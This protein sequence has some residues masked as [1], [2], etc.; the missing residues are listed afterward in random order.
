[1][2]I[3]I[4]CIEFH[5][6]ILFCEAFEILSTQRAFD[7]V[8]VVWRLAIWIVHHRLFAS[9]Y[10]HTV[11]AMTLVVPHSVPSV[12]PLT[13]FGPREMWLLMMCLLSY[14]W[15]AFFCLWT[16]TAVS[17]LLPRSNWLLEIIPIETRQAISTILRFYC[18]F[19]LRISWCCF[20]VRLWISEENKMPVFFLEK[21]SPR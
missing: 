18:S 14:H 9:Y 13:V 20:P 7:L 4:N 1:M 5:K 12:V 3:L 11:R 15:I 6:V 10:F 8:C 2:I 16:T 17:L 21:S 19:Q